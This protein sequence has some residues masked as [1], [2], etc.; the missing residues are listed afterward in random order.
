MKYRLRRK[1]KKYTGICTGDLQNSKIS[2][3]Q[4]IKS[5]HSLKK[6]RSTNNLFSPLKLTRI[7]NNYPVLINVREK[8]AFLNTAGG[9]TELYPLSHEEFGKIYQKH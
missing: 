3:E 8:W 9:S 5:S 1:D 2:N 6:K 4:K 7:K